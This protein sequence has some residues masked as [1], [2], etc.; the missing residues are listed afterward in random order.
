MDQELEQVTEVYNLIV[1]YLVTYSFQIFGAII[2]LV[3]GFFLGRKLSSIVLKLCEKKDLDITLSRFFAS[4]TRIAVVASAFVIALPKLGIQIT[5]FVAAIGALGLGAGLAV[6]GLLA[7]YGAGLSIILSRPFVVGDT[8]RVQGVWGIVKEV[9]L[10]FT[11][12]TN[13]DGEVITI[14]NK[15]I[16]GEII[17]NSQEDTVLELSVGIAY[18]SDAEAAVKAIREK[19]TDVDGLSQTRSVQIGIDSFGDSSV[20]LEVRCWVKTAQFYE[21]KFNSNQLIFAALKEAGIEIP[22]PQREVRML[23]DND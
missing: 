11:M 21:V 1:T 23:G 15:H 9:H 19:L 18:S 10:A 14:P 13:E 16:V 22:F 2:I 17:H 7:N 8:I 12:L 20:N 4:C 6:Q 5:P 3:L